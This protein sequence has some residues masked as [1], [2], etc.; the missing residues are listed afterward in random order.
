MV[1]DDKEHQ[2]DGS[3]VYRN[4]RIGNISIGKLSVGGPKSSGSTPAKAPVIIDA[5]A[6]DVVSPP[7]ASEAVVR[8]PQPPSYNEKLASWRDQLNPES[9]HEYDVSKTE[10]ETGLID[11]SRI[12]SERARLMVERR[13]QAKSSSQSNVAQKRQLGGN[14]LGQA[15]EK[16]IVVPSFM[17]DLEVTLSLSRLIDPKNESASIE[18]PIIGN[19]VDPSTGSMV[20]RRTNRSTYDVNLKTEKGESK[21]VIA[22]DKHGEATPTFSGAF[23]SVTQWQQPLRT[24][25]RTL[26]ESVPA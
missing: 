17:S 4:V 23:S 10:Q 14:L 25:I 7:P 24:T 20:I 5:V 8:S 13:N 15:Y 9:Q 2:D 11:T 1:M 16:M 26:A 22:P 6:R 18:I 19:L 21:V 12:K 3:K